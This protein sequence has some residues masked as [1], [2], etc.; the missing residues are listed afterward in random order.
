LD[1]PAGA[2]FC[3]LVRAWEIDLGARGKPTEEDI[4]HCAVDTHDG[5]L[6]VDELEDTSREG[7]YY[8]HLD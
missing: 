2:R 3:E 8:L 4:P 1:G 7:D 5:E 6:V